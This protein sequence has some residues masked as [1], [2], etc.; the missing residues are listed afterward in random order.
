M[1]HSNIFYIVISEKGTF[2]DF[3]LSCVERLSSS[4][5]L[6]PKLCRICLTYFLYYIKRFKF[7]IKPKSETK[8]MIIHDYWLMKSQESKAV[9]LICI[10]DISSHGRSCRYGWYSH[11][12]T[13]ICTSTSRN[14]F[15]VSQSHRTVLQVTIKVDLYRIIFSLF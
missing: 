14:I 10:N 6:L 12:H 9:S 11:G 4:L 13:T 8:N 2:G 5:R 7:H 1:H 3:F 15:C